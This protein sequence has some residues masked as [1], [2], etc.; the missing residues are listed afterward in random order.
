MAAAKVIP[1]FHPLVAELYDLDA[2]IAALQEQ[3][4]A[5][6]KK[7]IALGEGNYI[8]EQDRRATVIVPK[9]FYTSYDLYK[10]DAYK[11][12]LEARKLKK[13]SAALFKEFRDMRET[14]ARDLAGE[15]F[16]TLFDRMVA[17]AP[18]DGF[19]KIAPKLLTPAKARDIILLCQLVKPPG[20]AHV[21]L[22]D[23]PKKVAGG[24]VEE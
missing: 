15:E 12:F 22:P 24:D 16:K 18:T 4:D 20:E 21:K 14:A 7:L 5:V 9:G 3:R 11:A 6:A 2:Q 13:G 19:E 17:F 10:N 23:K 8:D 1:T